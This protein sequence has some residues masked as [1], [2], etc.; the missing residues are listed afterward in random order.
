MDV[1]VRDYLK[2][3]QCLCELVGLV[4]REY[5][6]KSSGPPIWSPILLS[7]IIGTAEAFLSNVLRT[8]INYFPECISSDIKKISFDQF[9]KFDSLESAK[10]YLAQSLV[11][12]VVHDGPHGWFVFLEW[13]AHIL[14]PNARAIEH[15]LV[16]I[17]ERHNL[18]LHQNGVVNKTYLL[19]VVPALR[20]GVVENAALDADSYYLLNAISRF[21]AGLLTITAE[22]WKRIEPDKEFAT[23]ELLGPH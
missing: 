4:D 8:Y 22:L 2:T 14:V 17:W 23:T 9:C 18:L 20:N 1:L 10:S 13:K 16:E 11:D 6:T 3:T 19:A 21:K 5:K 12:E 15:E 7:A